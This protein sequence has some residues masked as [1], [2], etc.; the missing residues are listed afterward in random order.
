MRDLAPSLAVLLIA[1]ILGGRVARRFGLPAV[2]GELTAGMLVGPAALAWVE[3]STTLERMGD[4]GIISLLFIVGV[5][6]DARELRRVGRNALLVATLGAVG[7][8]GLG[9]AAASAFGAGGIEAAFVGGV[10]TATSVGVTAQVLGERR[11]LQTP[12]GQ[13]VLGAAVVDD[14]FGLVVLAL[15]V[16]ITERDGV[17][18]FSLALLA[19]RLALFL[20]L[21]F[22]AARLMERAL[23]WRQHRRAALI[24]G[25]LAAGLTGLA[26]AVGL[27][28]IVGAFAAGLLLPPPD[29]QHPGPGFEEEDYGEVVEASLEAPHLRLHQRSHV[30]VA[31]IVRLAESVSL[32]FAPIFFVIVGARVDPGS[33]WNI[34]LIGSAFAFLGLGIAGKLLAGLGAASGSRLAVGLAMVPRG[35]V[36]LVFAA[37]GLSAGVF[38]N[39]R[40]GALVLAVAGT[41]LV[42]PFLLARIR[43]PDLGPPGITGNSGSGA[44]PST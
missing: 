18:A 17:S 27:A 34:K 7:S 10:L 20:V 41:T 39:G 3:P 4:L 26:G 16:G 11:A 5:E 38:E 43:L 1:A 35:E 8:F 14:V 42:G 6:T 25:V 15:L 24:V 36:G 2:L 19:A 13:T 32:R 12:F 28:P 33:G 37:A 40:Y 44:T 9:F 22:L 30:A 29:E 23:R 21:F 31:P